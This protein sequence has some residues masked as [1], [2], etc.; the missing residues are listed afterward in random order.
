[1]PVT[2][3]TGIMQIERFALYPLSYDSELGGFKMKKRLLSI[4]LAMTMLLT[5]LP[6]E[7]LAQDASTLTSGTCGENLTWSYNDGVL[8]IQGTGDMEDYHDKRPWDDFREQIHTVTI[9]NGVDSIG[10]K[11]FSDC[12]SLTSVAIPES[13]TSIESYAFQGCTS[14]TSISIP[15]GVWYIGSYMFFGCTSL[16]DVTIPEGVKIIGGAAF[17]YCT[18]LTSVTIPEGVSSINGYMFSGCSRLRSVTIPESVTSIGAGAFEDCASLNSMTIPKGVTSIGD[19]AFSGCTSLADVYYSGSKDDWENISIGSSNEQLLNTAIHYNHTGSGT[20]PVPNVVASGTCG[21]NLTWNLN[22]AGTLT[23]SGTGAMTDYT[24]SSTA[25]WNNRSG[26]IKNVVIENNVVSIGRHAFRGC[27]SLNSVTVGNSVTSIGSDAFDWCQNLTHITIPSSVT[28]IELSVF[29]YCSGLTSAGPI[30]SGCNYEFG[31]TEKIPERA[32]YGISL[33]SATI[34]DSITSIESYAFYGCGKLTSIKIPNNVTNIGEYAFSGCR[35]VTSVTI[36]DSVAN[37]GKY[38]FARCADLVN[39][40]MPKG[41]VNIGSGV[42]S[43]CN[44]LTD[45]TLPNSINTI[46]DHL[47]EDC[48]GLTSM[49]IPNDVTHIEGYAFYGC[50][51]LPSLTIPNGVTNIEER[52]FARCSALVSIIIP[53]SVTRIGPY[54]FDSCSNL[55]HIYYAG[56]Q[57]EWA[58]VSYSYDVPSAATI[59]YNSTGPDTPAGDIII[60]NGNPSR[61]IKVGETITFPVS[62]PNPNGLT[63]SAMN[64]NCVSS[65]SNVALVT[66]WK[67]PDIDSVVMNPISFTVAVK[68][69][70]EGTAAITVSVADGRSAS[71]EMMVQPK[72]QVP[73]IEF[74]P[75]IYH[76]NW[77]ITKSTGIKALER[78]TPSILLQDPN[79]KVTNNCWCTF[80]AI[81]SAPSDLYETAEY[82]SGFSQ[83]DMYEALLLDALRATVSYEKTPKILKEST[84]YVK[85]FTDYLTEVVKSDYRLDM[86]NVED[87][88]KLA[89]KTDIEAIIDD[90]TDTWF[91]ENHIG[92]STSSKIVGFMSKGIKYLGNFEDYLDYITTCMTLASLDEQTRDLLT[93]AYTI[94]ATDEKYSPTH[95]LTWAIRECIEMYDQG[96]D[97]FLSSVQNGSLKVGG[98]LGISLISDGVWDTVLKKAGMKNPNVTLILA[99]ISAGKTLTNFFYNTDDVAERYLDMQYIT[100]IESIFDCV[101]TDA[102]E[103]FATARD[104]QSANLLLAAMRLS[105]QLRDEDCETAS[106]FQD[107]LTTDIFYKLLGSWGY[108]SWGGRTTETKDSIKTFQNSYRTALHG[109]ETGWIYCLEEDYPGSGRFEK[110][111]PLIEE[112]IN[113]LTKEVKVQCPV[114]VYVYDQSGT[115]VAYVADGKMSCLAD[116]LIIAVEGD[117]KTICFLNDADYRIECIG[118][119]SGDMD[120]AVI[121]HTDDEAI[122]RNVNYN[123]LSVTDGGV[124]SMEVDSQVLANPYELKDATDEK[125]AFNY[126]SMG[127]SMARHTVKVISGTVRQMGRE[128]IETTAVYGEVLELRAMVPEGYG[129]IKWNCTSAIANI[130]DPAEEYT[131]FIMPDEDVVITAVL[132]IPMKAYRIQFDANGGPVT[133]VQQRTESNGQLRSLPAIDLTRKGYT[134]DGWFTALDGGEI[135]DESRV[136]TEGTTL[137]AHWTRSSAL[138]RALNTADASTEID[139]DIPDGLIGHGA[140]AVA[141]RYENGRMVE[142]VFG[143]GLPEENPVK[144][145]ARIGWNQGWKIFFL[146]SEETKPL[147]NPTILAR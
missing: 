93:Q 144:F 37:I 71:C 3:K 29:D 81:L 75:D 77:L 21:E 124:Y 91:K 114:N 36:P 141:A 89:E 35:G 132:L 55:K 146:S 9:D 98:R 107:A 60:D 104:V 22:D 41:I 15:E 42:F 18:S 31:W 110:Y 27:A 1:M 6:A 53:D 57:D 4:L 111:E 123:G 112:S 128:F 106:Q 34:P 95:P 51:S 97:S 17:E 73:E 113:T 115:I 119:D 61:T 126:D 33:T 140:Q 74:D 90:Y 138:V 62:V 76:A 83:R 87:Y 69:V 147:C 121:E 80:S 44:S 40:S 47:F 48:T 99:A 103:K 28:T 86:S 66:F 19:W 30:G 23:I 39:V 8:H 24:L 139:F 96:S 82:F 117:E 16:A 135:V 78:D 12:T 64:F 134:F 133:P 92:I 122:V 108:T 70:K 88:Q 52:A 26:L 127:T 63:A 136:Y 54:A 14:L 7:A 2:G 49:V 68:G 65:D 84:G 46:R 137:Y 131:T 59:H 10:Q 20:N 85:K 105:F 45:A 50:S 129:F 142:A 130:K 58:K 32:F 120:I 43:G 118:Y 109:A 100:E 79:S 67:G 145:S 11:A 5:L 102:S 13:V 143:V 72:E 38:A 25:P 94:C 101:Y 125:V 116:D 56:S